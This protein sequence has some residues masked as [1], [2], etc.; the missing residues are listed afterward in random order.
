MPTSP[1]RRP[2]AWLPALLVPVLAW[3]A[4]AA[5]FGRAGW[6]DWA[7]PHWLE[8]DPVEVYARVR[9]AAE[10]PGHALASFTRIERLGAPAAADWSA[11]PVPDRL[12]FV[13]TGLL[14]RVT[15]I[16]AA[17]HLMAAIITGLNAATFFLCARWLRWRWEWAAALGVVFALG[18]Y[19]LRW[20]VTLSLNQTFV[21]PPLVL[22][23]ARAARAAPWTGGR[24]RWWGLAVLTGLWL[25]L[26]NPYLAFFAGIVGGGALLLAL[27]RRAPAAR[28]RLLAGFL[29][30]LVLS[31]VAANA[32]H[33]LPHLRGTTA[34]ALVRGAGDIRTYALRP[35]DWV[36][37]PADH[38]I[39]ALAGIGRRYQAAQEGRGEFAYNYLGAAGLAGLGL[40]LFRSV[41]HLRRRRWSRVDP[42]LGLAWITVFGVA[43]GLY[44][45]LAA[46]GLDQFRAASRI[47]VYAVVWALFCLG[48]W[49]ARRSA[50]L[51]RG[52][53][54]VLAAL[55]MVA[56]VWEQTPPLSDRAGPRQNQARWERLAAATAG[57]EAALPPGA[58][59]FQLP[60]VPFPEAGP[61]RGMTDYE[62]FLPFLASSALRFSYGQLRPSPWL[63]WARHVE[64]LPAREMIAALEHT[65]FAA[66][67][68]D[69]R[70][71]A[72]AADRLTDELRQ[73]GAVELSLP[74]L[75][76][77][78]RVFR[79]NPAAVPRLP[80]LADPRLREPWDPADPASRL[81]ALDGWYPLES[82]G[83][84][85]WRWAAQRAT[86]GW[87]HD[88]AAATATLTFRLQGPAGAT[89]VLRAGERE[90][91]RGRPAATGVRVSVPL[92][93]GMNT[94]G[95]E[96]QGRTFSPG[97]HDP[98]ELGFMVENPSLSV[99]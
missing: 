59:V 63:H 69:R 70:A 86:L 34:E 36:A 71:Y 30:C 55:L 13:L 4:L 2:S 98:R 93:P 53:S 23:C 41:R 16:F 33:L 17:V 68:I 42:L 90:I 48:S 56:A 77:T 21:L 12:V 52:V 83:S 72:D 60:A 94:L 18:S 24:R 38:R 82:R 9:I 92:A 87:W 80:D 32:A 40:L 10:Q 61:V 31:F 49:A 89:V 20:G 85:R 15:G 67:W 78:H 39:G 22:L 74:G 57:L 26:S 66:L 50:G 65:G 97:G 76:A 51:P 84:A 11:Y 62:H 19:N 44:T 29:A 5:V 46:A 73:A 1:L 43:G 58:A 45:W 88:G 37:P 27:L 28:W 75:A 96:L 6:A 25:G 81:L 64:R 91:W 35:A 47:G 3:V 99:P 8:G 14:A 79:L 95:W 54:P 7:A